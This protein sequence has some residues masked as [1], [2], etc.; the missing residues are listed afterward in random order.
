[1]GPRVKPI[2]DAVAQLSAIFRR[3]ASKGEAH[4]QSRPLLADLSR[5]PRFLPAMLEHHLRKPGVLNSRNF[6]TVGLELSSNPYFELVAN[7]WI[8]LPSRET[9]LPTKTIHH[10]GPL[11][12]TTVTVFGPGYEH[13]TFTRPTPFGGGFSVIHFRRP[14]CFTRG[15][16]EAGPAR[17]D[18]DP[19]LIS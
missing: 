8:P 3:S 19:L 10:H 7:C 17:R 2:D 14:V 9:H 6:P 11:L 4:E 18:R 12:L 15:C 5:E 16:T 1:M 13:W